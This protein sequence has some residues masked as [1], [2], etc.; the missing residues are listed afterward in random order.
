MPEASGRLD[1]KHE[2]LYTIFAAAP[3]YAIGKRMGEGTDW[4][5]GEG[6]YRR[7]Q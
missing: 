7:F 4:K 2:Q 3:W 6:S 5:Q 1:C